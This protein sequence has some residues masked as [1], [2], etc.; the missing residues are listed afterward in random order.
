MGQAAALPATAVPELADA[1]RCGRLGEHDENAVVGGESPCSRSWASVAA[2]M[3]WLIV[4]KP[5]H[6]ASSS[7]VSHLGAMGTSVAESC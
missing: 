7:G 4:R 6:I 5:R 2:S 1:Q 3:T